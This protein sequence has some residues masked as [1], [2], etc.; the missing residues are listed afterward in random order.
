MYTPS[1]TPVKYDTCSSGALWSNS[2]S[3]MWTKKNIGR[4]KIFNTVC[5]I[6]HVWQNLDVCTTTSFLTTSPF[7]TLLD[8]LSSTSIC[9]FFRNYVPIVKHCGA[10]LEIG[11]ALPSLVSFGMVQPYHLYHLCKRP[12]LTC[13]LAL[14][15]DVNISWP[16]APS[17]LCQC[18][19]SRGWE[20]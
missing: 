7:H 5:K 10:V 14:S 2:I 20:A 1:T 13:V 19:T 3:A 15:H 18:Y 12:N 11:M 8:S 17:Q 4:G 9:W 16:F 6:K